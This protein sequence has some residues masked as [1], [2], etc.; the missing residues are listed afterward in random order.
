MQVMVKSSSL[1]RASVADALRGNPSQCLLFIA[2]SLPT[3]QSGQV[4]VPFL[5]WGSLC[6]DQVQQPKLSPAFSGDQGY[7]VEQQSK[8]FLLWLIP[9][10]PLLSLKTEDQLTQNLFAPGSFTSQLLQ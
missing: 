9:N 7:E 1:L 6:C 10:K 5:K 2:L 8:I 3:L 4:F